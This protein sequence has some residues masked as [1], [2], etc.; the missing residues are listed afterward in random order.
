MDFEILL[1]SIIIEKNKVINLKFLFLLKAVNEDAPLNKNT[2][3]IANILVKKKVVSIIEI[4]YFIKRFVRKELS[5]NFS[6]Y[7]ILSSNNSNN[8]SNHMPLRH[9]IQSL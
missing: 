7:N 4:F 6:E 5:I 3:K 2:E 8:I 9:F 1:I